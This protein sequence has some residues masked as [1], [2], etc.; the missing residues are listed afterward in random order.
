[1][2]R[3]EDGVNKQEQNDQQCQD[4]LERMLYKYIELFG[5]EDDFNMFVITND[6]FK[7]FWKELGKLG[8]AS[9]SSL[10]FSYKLEPL[11]EERQKTYKEYSELLDRII[12]LYIQ[13]RGLKEPINQTVFFSDDSFR[14]LLDELE[15]MRRSNK[16]VPSRNHQFFALLEK[17][18]ERGGGREREQIEKAKDRLPFLLELIEEYGPNATLSEIVETIKENHSPDDLRP[19]LDLGG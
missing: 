3:K 6:D 13:K 4:I 18:I 2:T 17:Y 10:Y 7:P 15:A 1:M 16:H 12:D 9:G 14:Q 19:T 5:I 11:Y 8:W